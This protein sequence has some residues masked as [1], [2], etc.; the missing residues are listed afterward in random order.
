MLRSAST[1]TDNPRTAWC[2]VILKTKNCLEVHLLWKESRNTIKLYQTEKEKKEFG[3]IKAAEFVKERNK[4]GNM[5]DYYKVMNEYGD[6]IYF[7]SSLF[8]SSIDWK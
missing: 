5:N 2:P 4:K 7:R 8:E 1:K 6:E 3:R